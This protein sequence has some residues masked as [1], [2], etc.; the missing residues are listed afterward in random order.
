MAG[1][2]SGRTGRRSRAEGC[3]GPGVHGQ[4]RRIEM[5]HTVDIFLHVGA[6]PGGQAW[7]F[8][9]LYSFVSV[10]CSSSAHKFR[11]GQHDKS[12]LLEIENI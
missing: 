11:N 2:G 9:G 6:S 3:A 10:V 4:E 5:T 7:G 12:L 1:S 8:R